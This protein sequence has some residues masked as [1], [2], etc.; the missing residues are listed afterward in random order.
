METIEKTVIT[1]QATIKARMSKVWKCWTS[2]E[3]IVKW[4]NASDDWHTPKAENDLRTGG[5]FNS[6]MEAKDGSMGFDFWGVY[7]KVI[8]NKRIEYTMGDGRKVKVI[9]NELDSNKTEVIESFEAESENSVV[10]QQAGW[11]SILNNF[12]N[13]TENF[14]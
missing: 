6:R 9:F 2:P 12:K 13:Y 4:N 14:R 8:L 1:V 5:K 10:L 3:D 11:Q 7:D